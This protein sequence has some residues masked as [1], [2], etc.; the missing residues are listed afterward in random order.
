MKNIFLF[1]LLLFYSS[2]KG[3][4]LAPN[5]SALTK[6]T[7][8][9]EV[10]TDYDPW[11]GE[12]GAVEIIEARTAPVPR[13]NKAFGDIRAFQTIV[14]SPGLSFPF[15]RKLIDE[16][17]RDVF[18]Q[19]WTLQEIERMGI[20][21]PSQYRKIEETLDGRLQR[22]VLT[23]PVSEEESMIRTIFQLQTELA[24]KISTLDSFILENRGG[25]KTVLN[26]IYLYNRFTAILVATGLMD[27]R[28]AEYLPYEYRGDPRDLL[29]K[30][31]KRMIEY[32]EQLPMACRSM[33]MITA[34]APSPLP[35]DEPRKFGYVEWLK[36]QLGENLQAVVVYGSSARE[37]EDYHDYDNWV[38]VKDLDQAYS[39]LKGAGL[40]YD[41]ATGQVH[42][43]GK[44]GK[45][46][47]LNLATESLYA[48]A[49]RYNQFCDRALNQCKIIYGSVRFYK[50]TQ[51][52]VLER[53]ISSCYI[54]LKMLRS[55][56]VWIARNPEEIVGKPALFEFFVKNAQFFMT[57]RLNLHDKFRV[58][59]KEELRA[60]L[61]K[62]GIAPIP[63][64]PDPAYIARNMIQ[65][66]VNASRI[67]ALFLQD[68]TPDFSFFDPQKIPKAIKTSMR[69]VLQK[70]SF[71]K[72]I[73]PFLVAS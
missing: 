25:E 63:Y 6:Q 71:G 11:F 69:T 20:Y 58:I 43:Q 66:A 44:E 59:S 3:F 67:H 24:Q 9:L 14:I 8:G 45:E 38:I 16:T 70:R 34:K 21:L 5:T 4:A 33:E 64:E 30:I 28:A 22:L 36:K 37:N 46:V 62:I 18:P 53:S 26:K 65:A 61:A 49:S 10:G 32:L 68:V 23:N 35:G 52:E 73:L 13:T 51:E 40:T 55:C 27:P 39:K 31:K 57:V 19:P 41:I 17:P 1:L 12:P 42:W 60:E 29:I 15:F 48:F 72:R 56:A 7:E 54:R 2:E 50:V 47:T